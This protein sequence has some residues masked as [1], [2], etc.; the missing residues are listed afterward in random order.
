MSEWWLITLGFIF[1]GLTLVLLAVVLFKLKK[2]QQYT[3]QLLDKVQ[4]EQ[5]A[6]LAGSLGLGRRLTRCNSSL[7]HLEKS[8]QDLHYKETSDKSFEQAS[9]MLQM[10]ASI[11]DIIETCH[12]SRGEA[13]LINDMLELSSTNLGHSN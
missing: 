1:C 7:K 11:D 3:V 6:L 9:R 5:K 2:Q 10:G 13:E 8:Q 4:H 12:L